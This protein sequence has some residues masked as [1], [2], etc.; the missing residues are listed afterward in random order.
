MAELFS[1]RLFVHSAERVFKI[2]CVSIKEFVVT[3]KTGGFEGYPHIKN[4]YNHV[5]L[6]L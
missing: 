4:G 5:V 3:I 2:G 1:V 6:H